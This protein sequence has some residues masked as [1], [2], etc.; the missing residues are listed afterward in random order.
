MLRY[1]KKD[2][3]IVC[4]IELNDFNKNR[5]IIFFRQMDHASTTDFNYIE[6]FLSKHDGGNIYL[7]KKY[8]DEGIGFIYIKNMNK[9]NAISGK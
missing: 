5:K 8:S 6:Q 7:S 2:I 9:R 4:K 1:I 3:L